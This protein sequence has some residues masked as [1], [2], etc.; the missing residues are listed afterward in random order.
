MEPCRRAPAAPAFVNPP[1]PW[2]YVFWDQ[3][4]L[5]SSS[6]T[7]PRRPSRPCGRRCAG[8][9]VC[10][11]PGPAAV[12]AYTPVTRARLPGGP[13]LPAPSPGRG[14]AA[15]P[16]RRCAGV[17]GRLPAPSSP[18]PLLR[19]VPRPSLP[20][21]PYERCCLPV[22]GRSVRREPLRRP[23]LWGR[24]APAGRARGDWW[25]R[26][27]AARGRA[28]PP[29]SPAA[30]SALGTA[31]APA[32]RGPSAR[33]RPGTQVRRR[34]GAGRGAG[35]PGRPLRSRQR[36]GRGSRGGRSGERWLSGRGFCGAR[37]AQVGPPVPVACQ[38]LLPAVGRLRRQRQLLRSRLHKA[39][40]AF[41][42][43][44]LLSGLMPWRINSPRSQLWKATVCV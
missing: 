12:S 30:A 36:P 9:Q 29:R 11:G 24:A 34:P 28:P 26:R 4:Q 27:A 35:R 39:A 8:R 32:A 21:G 5:R 20:I 16:G 13:F 1:L 6:N 33:G 19:E 14:A 41:I 23:A 43:K 10:G 40:A 31:P 3:R 42:A 38:H 25:V 44:P 18:A 15:W 2:N 17:A 7:S 37:P 22:A